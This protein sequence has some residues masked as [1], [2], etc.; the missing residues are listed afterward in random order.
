VL[1]DLERA[2]TAAPRERRIHRW[3]MGVHFEHGR[4]ELACEHLFREARLSRPQIESIRLHARLGNP[5]YS[6]DQQRRAYSRWIDKYTEPPTKRGAAV[7]RL[8][9]RS[10]VSGTLRIGYLTGEYSWVPAYHFLAGLAH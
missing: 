3:L 1:S 4:D 6:V 8:V 9:S 7:R 10:Q 2:R 5:T